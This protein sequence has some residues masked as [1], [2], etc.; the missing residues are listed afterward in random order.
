[1]SKS[2][3]ATES[4]RV[5]FDPR[6]PIVWTDWNQKVSSFFTVGEVLQY[7][8]RRVPQD[9]QIIG[10]ILALSDELD[11]LREEWGSPVGVTS[12]YRPPEINRAAGGVSNSQHLLGLA[13]DIYTMD[14]EDVAFERFLDAHWGGALGYG[15]G[16]ELGFT[17][18]D[19]RGG[20]WRKGSKAIRWWY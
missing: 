1:M 14:G 9:K 17:H 2:Q 16:S 10:N 13:A 15:V 7:D 4:I 6:A 8:S 19:L 20:G 11:L 18:V 3:A 5:P 12:W